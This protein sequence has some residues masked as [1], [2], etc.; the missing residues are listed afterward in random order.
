MITEEKLERERL[1]MKK[2]T[3]I[4]VVTRQTV[5]ARQLRVRCQQCG[6][7]VPIVTPE[8]AAGVLRT[9]AREI[10]GLLAAG[11]LHAVEEASGASLIC[12]NSISAVTNEDEP[13][14]VST[15]SER[16]LPAP[17]NQTNTEGERQ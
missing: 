17:T 3:R 6:A 7:E 11:D 2:R 1:A 8:N 5:V 4:T 13:G 15:G 10:H 16:A 14:T 9:T 12:G